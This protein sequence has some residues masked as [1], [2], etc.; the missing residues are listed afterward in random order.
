VPTEAEPVEPADEQDDGD[1]KLLADFSAL[2]D[3]LS[4]RRE[5]QPKTVHE[6]GKKAYAIV[7]A[8]RESSDAT[9]EKQA[10][11]TRRQG[12]GQEPIGSQP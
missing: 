1:A 7:R 12:R 4:G 9:S 3:R 2:I 6:A 8:A 10:K 11:Q 5:Q